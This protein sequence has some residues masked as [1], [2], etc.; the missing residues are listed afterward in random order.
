MEKITFLKNKTA[1]FIILLS[2]SIT[3]CNDKLNLTNPSGVPNGTFWKTESDALFGLNGVFDAFQVGELA[4]TRYNEIDHLADNASTVNSQGWIEFETSTQTTTN[5]RAIGR[6]KAYYTVIQR[7]N[8]VINE[9][10]KISAISDV[11]KKRIIAEASFLRAWSYLDL[12]TLW[13]DV[14]LYIAPVGA[15]EKGKARTKKAEINDFL[16][17]E[18]TTVIIPNLPLTVPSSERGRI[19][20]DA[21]KALLG[22]IYLYKQDW[23][24]SAAI[25][26]EIIDGKRYELFPNYAR[27]FTLEG[28]YSKENLWEINFETGG[29]DNGETFAIRI[30][31]NQAPL[32][33]RSYWRPTDNFAN[34]F[35]CTDG[36]PIADSPLYGTKSPLYATTTAKTKFGTRDQRLRAT[37]LT[38]AD[39][40]P[41]NKR[42]WNFFSNS[43][44]ANNNF[45]IGKY[46][47]LTSTQYTGGPQ[48]YYMIRYADVLLMYAEAQNEAVG[49]DASVY[50]ATKLVRNR[51]AMPDYPVGLT[52]DKMRDYIRNERRWEFGYEHSRYFDLLRWRIAHLVLPTS[53]GKVFK[54]PRDYLWPYPQEEM[55][56][57]AEMKAG[58][59]NPEY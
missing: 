50:L 54:N 2:F 6:W 31:T 8:L 58:G 41:G 7:A 28:E 57:N 5:A 45:A 43:T 24:N 14:P 40:T 44:T 56:N 52:K 53:G 15:F 34:S 35:L 16:I 20:S 46:L 26:K 51:A 38:L 39:L 12:I 17:K 55:D 4:G 11:S 25:L 36:K 13:G 42:I 59:Q 47:T 9:V 1:L 21:A 49:P 22:K 3:S 30:D 18:L 23:T 10:G 48:N 32:R 37:I 19:T 33:P 27:L 29:V